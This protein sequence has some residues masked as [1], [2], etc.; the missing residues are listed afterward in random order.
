MCGVGNEIHLTLD[1]AGNVT[2]Q[3]TKEKDAQGGVTP[4]TTMATY[5]ALSR[6]ITATDGLG[7]TT[8]T[9]YDARSLVNKVQEPGSVNYVTTSTY[10][11]LNRVKSQTRPGGIKVRYE[12]DKSSRRTA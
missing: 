2:T 1:D 4:V 10:D 9:T 3:L 11:G 8:T 5:D 7:N 12:Y 6:P